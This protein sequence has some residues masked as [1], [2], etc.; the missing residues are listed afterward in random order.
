M[1]HLQKSSFEM[2]R[3]PMS[4]ITK[5]G[6]RRLH[7]AM[8]AAIVAAAVPCNPLIADIVHFVDSD[9]TYLNQEAPN[10]N[11]GYDPAVAATHNMEV[12]ARSGY[13]RKGLIRFDVT[14][15]AGQ[16]NLVEN[17]TLTLYARD[18]SLS[19]VLDMTLGLFA[20]SDA[21]SAWTEEGASWNNLYRH[22]PTVSWA[23]SAGA[24]TP[25]VDYSQTLLATAVDHHNSSNP[26]ALVF[27]LT[28]I[29][30]SLFID[31]I[32]GDN[33]GLMIMNIDPVTHEPVTAWTRSRIVTSHDAGSAAYHPDLAVTLIPEPGS[34]ALLG[35]GTTMLLLRRRRALEA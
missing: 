27:D 17:I 3:Q 13:L 10:N 33:N 30:D 21:N 5:G 29:K 7:F 18:N 15:L 19:N 16:E 25:G 35:L 4:F 24:H 11:Y 1:S 23:G 12:G 28:G 6:S 34:I 20:V 31:W 22:S 9:M 2:F 26:E 14:S 8:A 32:N